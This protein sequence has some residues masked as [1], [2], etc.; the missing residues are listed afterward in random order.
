LHIE[1]QT[2]AVEVQTELEYVELLENEVQA[3][4]KHQEADLRLA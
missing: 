4:L 1:I 2:C 3:K